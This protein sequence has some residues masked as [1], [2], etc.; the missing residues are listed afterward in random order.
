VHLVRHGQGEHNVE[1]AL[2][3][4][5]AYKKELVTGTEAHTLRR[6]NPPCPLCR[7]LQDARLDA[8]GEAQSRALGTRIRDARMQVDVVLVSPMTRAIQTATYMFPSELG[9][10]IVAVEM[11]REAHGDHPCDQRRPIS[12]IAK[13]FPHVNYSLIETDADVWHRPD[14]RWGYA[15]FL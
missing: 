13:D 5:A 3:G 2:S 6:R 4:S 11:C 15:A 10:P 14:R 7:S 1:A 9:V 12:V 8:T